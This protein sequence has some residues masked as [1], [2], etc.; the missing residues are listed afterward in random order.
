MGILTWGDGLAAVIGVHYGNQRKIYGAKTLDGL[1][2]II[3]AGIIA[4]IVYISLLVNFQS[5][6]LLKIIVISFIAAVIET[7]SP[8]NFDNLTIP[9]SIVVIYYFMY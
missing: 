2:T 6:D 8:S 1:L 7:L 3:V 5:V 4:S 9:L